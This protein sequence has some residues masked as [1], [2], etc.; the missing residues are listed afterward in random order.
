MPPGQ[1]IELMKPASA[2]GNWYLA[3]LRAKKRELFLKYLK[4]AIK[5]NQL[6]ELILALKTPQ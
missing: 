3:S 1:P 2:S 6:Q 5:Q 4:M